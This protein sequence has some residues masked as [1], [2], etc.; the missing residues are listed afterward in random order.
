M[1]DFAACHYAVAGLINATYS[2]AQEMKCKDGS[3]ADK[4]YFTDSTYTLAQ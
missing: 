2:L 4:N 3:M 1:L